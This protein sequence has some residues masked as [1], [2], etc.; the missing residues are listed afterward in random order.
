MV[1]NSLS[2]GDEAGFGG[3]SIGLFG[4][5]AVLINNLAGPT[6]VL[7]PALVQQAGWLPMVFFM[8]L[9]AVLSAIC[10]HM[11]L[12]T[13]RMM[14]GNSD[15]ERRVEYTDMA[16]HYLPW[17]VATFAVGAYFAYIVITVMTYIISSAH[18]VDFAI[19]DAFG[20]APGLQLLPSPGVLLC[21]NSQDSSTPFGN[22]EGLVVLPASFAIVALVCLP[23]A[24][25]NLDDNVMLQGFAVG[26]LTFIA[27]AW[28]ALFCNRL[29]T[30][31]ATS[32]QAIGIS[33]EGLLG[34]LL[35]NFAF[36]STLPSWANEKMPGVSVS[37]VFLMTMVYVVVLYSAI[38][39]VGALA[40][41]PYYHTDQTLF[42]KLS[43]SG[44]AVGMA[45]VVAY[46]IL[47]NFTSIPVL[48]IMLR[49]NLM[50]TAVPSGLASF[51]AILVPWLLSIPFYAGSG[52]QTL[53]VTGGMGVSSIVNFIVPLALYIVACRGDPK[54]RCD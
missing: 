4:S 7:L 48:S 47:Q 14:P 22:A 42:S 18:V 5:A 1:V 37:C 35:F 45:S 29:N 10:G 33:Q 31:S 36:M 53:A 51:L 46:P 6:V 13:M 50:Q 24:V 27:V 30:R 32:L 52:L 28:L 20:C 19:A 40:Y 2:S 8:V 41:A 49:Y 43:A 54:P 16:R 17:P 25:R 21:G 3:K 39:I 15:L 23:F 34:A 11:L 12:R 38:G 44:S 26:G 9:L